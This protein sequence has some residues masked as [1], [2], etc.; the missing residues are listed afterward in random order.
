MPGK[1]QGGSMSIA[2]AA[3]RQLAL[4]PLRSFCVS[5]PAGSGKTELLI[6]RYLG[7]L[8]RVKKPE[9]ILAITFTRK[10]AAEMRQR[11]VE[12]LW[13][14]RRGETCA[15]PHERTTRQLAENALLADAAGNWQLTRDVNRINIKTIDSFCGSLTRQMPVL[16]EFGGQAAILDNADELYR[17]AVTQL[18][19]DLERDSLVADDLRALL[20]HFDNNWQRVQ[21][22]LV[23]MLQ[24][25]DQWR[26]YVGLR[27]A[28][29]QAEAYLRQTVRSLIEEE[30]RV[31]SLALADYSDMLL[32]LQRYAADNLDGPSL[33]AFPG[34]DP[35]DLA[36]WRQLRDL[37]LTKQGSW[38]KTVDKRAGFPAGNAAEKA[39]KEELYGLIETL[40][41]QP[42]LEQALADLQNL[43]DTTQDAPSWQLVVHLFHVLPQLAAHLLLVFARR[44][45][46]DHSQVA[47]SALQA[48][49]EDE[50]PTELALRL[51]YRIEH[52]LVDEFQDTAINQFELVR[53]LTR[54]WGSHNEV[55]PGAPRTILIVGDGMQSIYGFRDANVGL[56]LKARQ[57]GFNGVLP[58]H[59]ELL[60]NFRSEEGIVD[61]VNETF[62]H[63]FPG[64]DDM[65]RGQVKFTEA[66][67]VRQFGHSPAV[68]C[69]GFGGDTALAQEVA[70]ICEQIQQGVDDS[71]CKSIAVLGRSRN[72]L[73]PFIQGL[74]Q[75]GTAYSAQ[76]LDSLGDSP[77]VMDLMSLC[78]ALANPADRVAWLALLRAPWC[79]LQLADLHA[80]GNWGE[81]P[82]ETALEQVIV[83]PALLA[84]L[85]DEGSGRLEHLGACLAAAEAGRD[86]LALRVWLEQLWLSL[87]GPAT[88]PED[89]HLQDV[90]RFFQ[91]L[92]QADQEGLGLDIN[93]LQ[94]QV[95]KLKLSQQQAGSKVE[96]MTLHKAKGLEFDWVLIPG[97]SRLTRSDSRELLLW[98]DYTM[99]TGE[100]GF[101]LAADDHSRDGEPTLYNYLRQQR[102]QKTRLETT[103]LL[104][105]GATRAA[106][107]L[108]LSACL[109]AD[110]RSGEWK[111]PPA[112]SLLRPMWDTF[113]QQMI[114]MPEVE[115]E[116]PVAT[117]DHSELFRLREIPSHALVAAP[118]RSDGEDANIPAR[119]HNRLERHAGTVVHQALEELSQQESLPEDVAVA[120]LARWGMALRRLGLCGETLVAGQA[121]LKQALQTTLADQQGRWVLSSRHSQARSEYALTRPAANGR[122]IDLVVDRTFVDGDTGERWIV[123]YKTSRPSAGQALDAFLAK[124]AGTYLQ[125]LQA[126]RSAMCAL[127]PEPVR[128]AL[129][130]TALGVLHEVT[131]GATES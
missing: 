129:Y 50:E 65:R 67:P 7:L 117:T 15:S 32:A 14:A 13:A 92:E 111:D 68:T 119:E 37:L 75:R 121:I 78:R 96:V 22:L 97:L 109:K 64:R 123:D 42:G 126:Y 24:R 85:S 69:H 27:H 130:F 88:V 110:E 1:R 131:F 125:Q 3:Q 90:E 94:Q 83:D 104:Y 70:F 25:R 51:D 48:L 80:V 127:G 74:R 23:S 39:R 99:T 98:D 60:C 30:L 2:D 54:G 5:A 26:E 62:S 66:A 72:H 89:G 12:A 106:Q 128:C 91:L 113:H 34:A 87:G 82:P 43:P 52:I 16:S 59:L 118:S 58:H 8:A 107:R 79:G 95:E 115:S 112:N 45:Q 21:D 35:L 116:T 6:Q 55:N 33:A 36:G 81:R 56:F 19:S 46:V 103:R 47:L 76:D 20:L 9:Q 49:G 40:R 38:R 53:R 4:D 31:L 105:V 63:A 61:W 73:Q 100:R 29:D 18:F 77:A 93:W 101:L 11:V 57:E 84:S 71:S 122:F 108:M 10:A 41:Q 124:E 44:G 114:V 102:K 120:D 17:E 86:R 28:P